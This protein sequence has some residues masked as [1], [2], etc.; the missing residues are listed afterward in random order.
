[1]SESYNTALEFFLPLSE[2]FILP[3]PPAASF[4]IFSPQCIPSSRHRFVFPLVPVIADISVFRSFLHP[5]PLL[6]PL[7]PSFLSVLY[8]FSSFSIY[9]VSLNLFYIPLFL[10]QETDGWP[11]M[12]GQLISSDIYHSSAQ[13]HTRALPHTHSSLIDQGQIL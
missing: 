6:P 4:V 5:F 7:L 3:F 2:A 13:T 12:A 1:M 8:P 11:V 9:P 10:L